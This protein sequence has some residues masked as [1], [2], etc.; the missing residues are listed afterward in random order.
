MKTRKYNLSAIAVG[1]ALA[2]A[3]LSALAANPTVANPA[4]PGASSIISSERVSTPPSFNAAEQT[5]LCLLES[6]AGL[7]AS[8][9]NDFGCP[10]S[11]T[12]Y[13]L[14]VFTTDTDGVG[15]AEIDY[16][17][18]NGGTTL[19]AYLDPVRDVGTRCR[20]EEA[21]GINKLKTV[22][23]V[24]YDGDHGWSRTSEI[25][26]SDAY[27]KLRDPQSGGINK[28]RE[29]DIK[30]YFKRVVAGISWEFDWGLEDIKK[31]RYS[32][33]ENSIVDRSA[34][35]ERGFY[36]PVQKWHEA[37]WY[38]HE[39]GQEGGLWL[40]K[41]QVIPRSAAGCQVRIEADDMFNGSGEFQMHGTVTVGK[42][43]VAPFAN[44]AAGQI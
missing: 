25:F 8:R 13:D 15:Q 9:T 17:V 31:F 1:V 36:Y 14:A 35:R 40:R 27:I 29:V 37:S 42:F 2:T 30:D 22:G 32:N 34:K 41:Y 43:P 16:G 7:L 21:R 5:G 20:V 4:V 23:V 19:K 28:Y 18:D 39:N 33:L 24:D 26:N 12:T 38:Q 11:G 10:V 6:V 3:S 44:R